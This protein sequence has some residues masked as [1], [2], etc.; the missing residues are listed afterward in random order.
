MYVISKPV[1]HLNKQIIDKKI[2]KQDD[3][4]QSPNAP[5]RVIDDDFF[6]NILWPSLSLT[7]N[8]VASYK[9][10][11]QWSALPFGIKSE[12]N[13]ISHFFRASRQHQSTDKRRPPVASKKILGSKN[14]SKLF[15]SP[16]HPNANQ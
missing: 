11:I 7:L 15:P 6:P 12:L 4:N 3:L 10:T 1:K 14:V 8:I 9:N 5:C 13:L 2:F 16:P